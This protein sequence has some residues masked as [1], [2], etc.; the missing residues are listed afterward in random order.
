MINKRNQNIIFTNPRWLEHFLLEKEKLN[1]YNEHIPDLI[2][3]I[4]KEIKFKIDKY[5]KLSLIVHVNND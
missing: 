5:M 3:K 1:F 2:A 4:L